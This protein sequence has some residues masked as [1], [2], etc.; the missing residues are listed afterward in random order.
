VLTITFTA[1]G[2]KRER[3]RVTIRNEALPRVAR[4]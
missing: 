1:R 4:A 2:W 3:A